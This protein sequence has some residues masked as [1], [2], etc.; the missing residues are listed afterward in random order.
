MQLELLKP[1]T[2]AELLAWYRVAY[3]K[4]DDDALTAWEAAERMRRRRDRWCVFALA[5]G[6]VIVG[7]ALAGALW[8]LV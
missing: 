3:E 2:D 7:A 5:E 1:T 4:L 8:W 6:A